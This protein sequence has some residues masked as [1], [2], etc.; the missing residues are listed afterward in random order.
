MKITRHDV[1]GYIMW[2]GEH[3]AKSGRLLLVEGETLS[4]VLTGLY[5]WITKENM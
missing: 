5:Q 3:R 1:N 4:D 2:L